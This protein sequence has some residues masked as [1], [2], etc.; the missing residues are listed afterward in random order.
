VNSSSGGLPGHPAL[1]EEFRLL[2][3]LHNIGATSMERSMSIE[4]IVRWTELSTEM[5]RNHLQK[6]GEL[7]YVEFVE[8]S[9]TEKYHVTPVGITKVMT[10]YS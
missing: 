10:L 8:V 2:C 6:L 4:E 7:G 9:G 3:M 5:L 1:P